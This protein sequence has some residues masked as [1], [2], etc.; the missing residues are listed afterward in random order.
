[1]KR[2]LFIALKENGQVVDYVDSVGVPNRTAED[3]IEM[4]V[5]KGERVTNM[6]IEKIKHAPKETWNKLKASFAKT[7]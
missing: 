4:I 5:A 1:M 6:V 3:L 7:N 2:A